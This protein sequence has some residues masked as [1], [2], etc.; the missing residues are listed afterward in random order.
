MEGEKKD[1]VD[2]FILHEAKRKQIGIFNRINC[3]KK[4]IAVN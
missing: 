1:I 3:T 4:K 2:I